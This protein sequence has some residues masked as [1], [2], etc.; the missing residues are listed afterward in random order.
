MRL[1]WSH[2]PNKAKMSKIYSMT[3]PD[4]YFYSES[5]RERGFLVGVEMRTHRFQTGVLA[6]EDSLEELAALADTANVEV[7]GATI[8]R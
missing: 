7:I 5:P 4:R 3:K 1:P 8:Q 6:I 2:F